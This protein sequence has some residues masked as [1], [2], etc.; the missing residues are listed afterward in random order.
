MIRNY[1]AAARRWRRIVVIRRP[2]RVTWLLIALSLLR[3]GLVLARTV[4]YG[5]GQGWDTINYIGVARNLLDGDGLVNV[6][7]V[8]DYY[9]TRR[10]CIRRCWRRRGWGSSTLM[11]RRRR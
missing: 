1:A 10:R 11:I 4:N 5:A 8:D 2:D 9:T 7:G 6:L 3:A